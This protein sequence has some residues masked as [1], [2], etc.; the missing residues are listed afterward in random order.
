MTH[1][2]GQIDTWESMTPH[3]PRR[4]SASPWQF[5]TTENSSAIKLSRLA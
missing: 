4:L 1:T 3:A 2:S 5:V